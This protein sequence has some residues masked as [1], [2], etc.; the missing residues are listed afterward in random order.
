MD[1]G[2]AAESSISI[3][4]WRMERSDP[5][6]LPPSNW[7]VPPPRILISRRSAGWSGPHNVPTQRCCRVS[8]I[9][10]SRPLAAKSIISSASPQIEI[11]FC[12]WWPKPETPL[13]TCY[14]LRPGPITSCY[15]SF[16]LMPP[17]ELWESVLP[18]KWG[19]NFQFWYLWR[20]TIENSDLTRQFWKED[21]QDWLAS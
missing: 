21:S 16:H 11:L 8:K 9:N 7:W 13:W 20:K 1:G 19:L 5:K 12:S 10:R 17:I 3:C 2:F 15:G 4:E 14:F 6:M 18:A